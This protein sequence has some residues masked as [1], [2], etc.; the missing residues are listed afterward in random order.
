MTL[1]TSINKTNCYRKINSSFLL[2]IT[3]RRF[4]GK[5]E[6]L[7]FK[8]DGTWLLLCF[9]WLKW[10]AS[11]TM[12]GVQVPSFVHVIFAITL[13]TAIWPNR[14]TI[15]RTKITLS[16]KIKHSELKLTNYITVVGISNRVHVCLQCVRCNI[17]VQGRS[18]MKSGT[19]GN[20]HKSMGCMQQ[21]N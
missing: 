8:S 7:N 16:L 11:A 13:W 3:R 2:R 10:L 18:L 5:V 21:D 4:L 6:R 19:K 9:E 14:S 17:L 1:W 12:V 15:Q 20:K